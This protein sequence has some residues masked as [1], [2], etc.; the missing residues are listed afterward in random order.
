MN[1]RYLS[2]FNP[3]VIST[4]VIKNKYAEQLVSNQLDLVGVIIAISLSLALGFVVYF[5]Y[6]ATFRGV[7][8]SQNFGISLIMMSVI[9]TLLVVTIS[10]NV[11]LSLGMVGALSIVR[12]RAAI[13]DPVDIMYLFWAISV[14]I[15]V[16]AGQYI[17]AI[18]ATIGIAGLCVVLSRLKTRTAPY[19]LIVRYQ[20]EEASRINSALK[21]LGGKVRSRVSTASRSEL[22]IELKG[23]PESNLTEE[24][25]SLPGVINAVLV[26]YNGEYC[27]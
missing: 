27:E 7:V 24:I 13:K 22:I 15:V 21:T 9:T 8:Y 17:L 19:L 20:T 4:S 10:S 1:L 6:K 14:G 25:S 2:A 12:F 16:G 3:S 18:A 5:I 23:E 11:V 26:D